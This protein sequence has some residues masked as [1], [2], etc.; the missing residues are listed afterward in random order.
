MIL[1][2]VDESAERYDGLVFQGSE[3]FVILLVALVVLGPERLPVVARKL[4]RWTAELRNAASDLR[5]GL[6]S[7][8]GDVKGLADEIRSPIRDLKKAAEDT[9]RD[10]REATDAGRWVGPKPVSGPTPEDA[11][12]DLEAIEGGTGPD[13]SDA[14]KAT[15]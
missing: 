4:G 12:K 13:E 14:D 1:I 9:T 3:I 8:L 5:S 11:M 2:S 10:A 15:G 7:E 6:E